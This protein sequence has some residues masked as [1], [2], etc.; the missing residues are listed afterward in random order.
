M[1]LDNILILPNYVEECATLI[2]CYHNKS[3]CLI[4]LNTALHSWQSIR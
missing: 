4:Q 1:G 3:L 2:E